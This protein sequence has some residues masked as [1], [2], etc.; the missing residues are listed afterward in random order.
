MPDLD[1]R[2]WEVIYAS[3][4]VDELHGAQ[5]WA[6]ELERLYDDLDENDDHSVA[7]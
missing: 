4:T 1:R 6:D 7:V 3:Y 2:F 5:I